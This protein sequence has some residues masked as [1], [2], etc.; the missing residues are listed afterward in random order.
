[1][2]NIWDKEGYSRVYGHVTSDNL[3]A[4][5]TYKLLSHKEI[6]RVKIYSIKILG[7][8]IEIYFYGTQLKGWYLFFLKNLKRLLM[9]AIKLFQSNDIILDR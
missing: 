8:K 4:I 1:M 3:P 9:K 6:G 5:W 7:W 2:L